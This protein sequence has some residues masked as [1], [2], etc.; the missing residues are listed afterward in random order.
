MLWA[1]GTVVLGIVLPETYV[2]SRSL[3]ALGLL[4]ACS[5]GMS[6]SGCALFGFVAAAAGPADV[7]AAYAGLAGQTVTILVWVDRGIRI[8]NSSL[9]LDISTGVQ[10]MILQAQKDKKKEVLGAT[11]PIQARSVLR[12]QAEHPEIDAQPIAE[13]APIFNVSRVIYIEVNDFATRPDASLEL[14]RGTALVSIKVMEVDAA[15]KPRVGFQQND[16]RVTYPKNTPPQGLP[17]SSDAK[18]YQG[19]VAELT[20]QLGEKFYTHDGE[21]E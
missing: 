7:K 17:S 16:I 8:D 13:V 12:Y 9:A 3:R 11:F 10:E 19:V 15:G 18:T 4:A 21:E 6:S 2:G 20:K 14:F 5:L 1:C